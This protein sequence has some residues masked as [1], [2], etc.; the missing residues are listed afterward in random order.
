ME[1]RTGAERQSEESETHEWPEW[2]QVS[3]LAGSSRPDQFSGKSSLPSEVLRC[4]FA[5]RPRRLRALAL[6]PH[7]EP[8]PLRPR[9]SSLLTQDISHLLTRVFRNLYSVEVIGEDVSASL[10][11]ARGSENARHEEFVDQLQQVTGAAAP[12]GGLAQPGA[13]AGLRSWSRLAGA[14]HCSVP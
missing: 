4:S 9:P 2:S 6:P 3:R 14:R 8:Q 10:I 11:Q 5:A 12:P 13:A 7:P 1:T